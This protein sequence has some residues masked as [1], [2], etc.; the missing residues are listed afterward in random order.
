MFVSPSIEYKGDCDVDN[1]VAF[2]WKKVFISFRRKKV[3][4]QCTICIYVRCSYS[5]AFVLYDI[6]EPRISFD[7]GR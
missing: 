6:V 3:L 7:F 1:T 5:A 2:Q 4:K